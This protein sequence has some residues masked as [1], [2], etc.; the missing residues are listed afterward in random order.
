MAVMETSGKIEAEVEE[1][2]SNAWTVAFLVVSLISSAFMIASSVVSLR[3]YTTVSDGFIDVIAIF[4]SLFGLSAEMRQFKSCRGVVNIWLGYVYF[5]TTYTGR[6]FL[7]LFLAAAVFGSGILRQ[8]ATG[9]VGVLGVL[10]F[11]VN[12]FSDL[13]RYAEK[14]SR[15]KYAESQEKKQNESEELP[16]A[17][18]KDK[19]EQDRYSYRQQYNFGDHSPRE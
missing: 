14:S 7:Y 1:P 11:V 13:P 17:E 5:I 10:I 6:S 15:R 2:G 3:S 4:L 9:M 19:Q 12:L 18:K 8:I 16:K